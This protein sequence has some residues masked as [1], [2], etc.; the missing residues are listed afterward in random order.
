M[1]VMSK[2]GPGQSQDLVASSGSSKWIPGAQAL[3]PPSSAHSQ[4]A[5]AKVERPCL[6]LA[7][8]R[9]TGVAG[10]SL[11]HNMVAPFPVL[12]EDFVR[13]VFPLQ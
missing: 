11:L 13:T 2:V 5:G 7:P 4:R 8:I 6:R 12:M 1:E 10:S 9:N 3:G